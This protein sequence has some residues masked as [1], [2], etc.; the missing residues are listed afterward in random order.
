MK[1]YFFLGILFFAAGAGLVLGLHNQ[2]S[3]KQLIE[4][5]SPK[6]VAQ[7][8]KLPVGEVAA[9]SLRWL[10]LEVLHAEAE[11]EEIV[12]IQG[13]EAYHIVVKNRSNA[14][15]DM[16]FKIR[17]EYHSYLDVEDLKTLRFEKIVQEGGYR[18]DEEIDFNHETGEA[19]YHSRLNGSHKTF[20]F[21]PG[22]VDAISAVYKFRFQPLKEGAE[23]RFP[24]TWD[25]E[26]Y[27]LRIPIVD[28]ELL[29]N[30]PLGNQET[31]KV[32]PYIHDTDN[33]D[34][35]SSRVSIWVS[36]NS[37]RIPLR[38]K[39]QVPI[40]GSVNAVLTEYRSG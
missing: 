31:V 34:I 33:P 40:A 20:K 29:E 30:S 2:S 4:S 13:R 19:I 16:I 37:D 1:R 10:G 39:T 5:I 11:I 8:K 14:F 3:Q 25:E 21:E 9:Y 15:L 6:I 7:Q 24:V 35:K 38:M 36:S 18:A 26:N 22:S 23:I 17:D 32:Q 28:K 12:P 27:D